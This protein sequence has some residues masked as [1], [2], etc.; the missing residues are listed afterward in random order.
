M[1][2]K[3][4]IVE[5]YFLDADEGGRLLAGGA[6]YIAPYID[7]E[8]K[9]AGQHHQTVK[10]PEGN[11]D[12]NHL[13]E[14]DEARA[15]R[16]YQTDGTED[17]GEAA[18]QDRFHDG[19]HGLIH[20]I[21]PPLLHL[22]IDVVVGEVRVK[23]H[24]E[25]NAHDEVYQGD[26]VQDDA[27]DGH[28]A[29]GPHQRAHYSEDS[30]E[31]G[32]HIW[33]EDQGDGHHD[34]AG[35][36]DGLQG[37]GEDGEV[38]VDVGEVAVVY[39]HVHVLLCTEI[40]T[41]LAYFDHHLFFVFGGVNILPLDNEPGGEYL[42]LVRVVA[43]IQRVRRGL[44]GVELADRPHKLC[45]GIHRFRPVEQEQLGRVDG[46]ELA[47]PGLGEVGVDVVG[48]LQGAQQLVQL[49]QCGGVAVV[50]FSAHNNT[51]RKN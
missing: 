51:T 3:C 16:E 13:E 22:Q 35:S 50:H 17:G 33:Q 9:K 39:N 41:N 6:L 23:V 2:H 19:D 29:E 7:Q 46:L 28:E 30:A 42:R 32:E 18:L 31:G 20:H 4:W 25:T 36:E 34:D 38:L 5:R 49:L 45:L 21:A 37:L 27:P 43:D 15:G 12:E 24:A 40:P 48:G 47:E 1:F 11:D 10:D 14:D 26:P 8:L 44:V